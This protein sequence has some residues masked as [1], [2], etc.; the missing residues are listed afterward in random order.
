MARP[1]KNN[2][3]YF[4]H[5]TTMRN[6]KKVKALRSKFGQVEGYAF[7]AMFLEY[8]TEQD[9]NEIENS[10]ME[11]EMFS[12]EL[13]IPVSVTKEI[14][15]YCIKIELLFINEDNFI[16]SD[17]LDE[18][19]KPVYEKR[20]RAKENSKTRKRRDTGVFVTYKPTTIGISA[21][22]IKEKTIYEKIDEAASYLTCPEEHAWRD[23]AAMQ[24]KLTIEEL[25]VLINEFTG[26]QKER[27]EVETPKEFR[28]HFTNWLKIEK[29]KIKNN[30]NSRRNLEPTA[31]S[32]AESF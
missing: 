26:L 3:E 19:L 20:R 21:T 1:Q 29:Q 25:I 31:H 18:F 16:Y 10:E 5:L 2:C 23:I 27:G 4:P 15:G 14:I 6:H 32:T 9:G 30:G 22:E 11:L 28:K 17:S 7:W 24:N 8:L 12:G 13:G